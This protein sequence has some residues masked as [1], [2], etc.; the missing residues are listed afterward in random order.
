MV[1][2]HFAISLVATRLRNLSNCIS[3]PRTNHVRIISAAREQLP[4]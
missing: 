2:N 3:Q 1:A 4:V